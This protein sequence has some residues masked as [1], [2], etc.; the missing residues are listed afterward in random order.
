QIRAYDDWQTADAQAAA[1]AS[2]YYADI[3]NSNLAYAQFQSYLAD[4]AY[5]TAV[6]TGVGKLNDALASQNLEVSLPDAPASTDAAQ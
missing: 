1:G 4:P 3:A 5:K 6:D 2:K